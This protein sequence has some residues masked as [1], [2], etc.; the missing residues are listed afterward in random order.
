MKSD[1]PPRRPGSA[2]P[3]RP[4]IARSP[5]VGSAGVGGLGTPVADPPG[6]AGG[7]AADLGERSDR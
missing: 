7:P 3:S 6:D 2:P 5:D 4:V 1:E